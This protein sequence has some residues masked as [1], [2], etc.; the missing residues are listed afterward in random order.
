[1]LHVAAK[2]RRADVR[3]L[4]RYARPGNSSLPTDAAAR[5]RRRWPHKQRDRPLGQKSVGQLGGHAQ[6]L[7]TQEAGCGILRR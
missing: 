5:Y 2:S 6:Y 7:C 1:M 3:S 4:Y